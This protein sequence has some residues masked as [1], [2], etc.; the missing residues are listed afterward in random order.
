MLAVE[1]LAKDSDSLLVLINWQEIL[2]VGVPR[3]VIF[4]FCSSQLHLYY[5]N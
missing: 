2:T 5:Y 3:R 1:D 4:Y